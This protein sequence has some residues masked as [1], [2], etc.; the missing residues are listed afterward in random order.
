VRKRLGVERL[1]AR[2]LCSADLATAFTYELNRI[3]V[4]PETFPAAAPREWT[5]IAPSQPLAIHPQLQRTAFEHAAAMARDDFFA[6]RHPLGGPHP[7]GR[8]REAGYPLHAALPDDANHVELI[9]G[10]QAFS[11]PAATLTELLNDSSRPTRDRR[12]ALLGLDTVFAA[13]G[14]VGVGY[15][16][17]PDSHLE[18]Y[19]T[20]TL[21]HRTAADRFLTGVV[22]GDANANGRY[23]AGE[24]TSGVLVRSGALA[25]TS[26]ATG[27]YSLP[28]GPGVHELIVQANAEGP[29]QRQRVR[30]TDSNVQIDFPREAGPQ[31]NFRSRSLWTHPLRHLDVNASGTIEPLDALVVINHLNRHGP[32]PLSPAGTTSNLPLLDTN[33]DAAATPLDAL[34]V[35][36]YLNRDDSGGE[37]EPPARADAALAGAHTWLE[38]TRRGIT[39]NRQPTTDNRQPTTDN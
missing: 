2:R 7:N 1:Q 14:E 21:A 36:N 12:E 39:D 33:G 10:G 27:A 17:E 3:R 20:I 9:A 34:L 24:G 26:D 22:Y 18:H 4:A 35:I 11:T 29:Q 37:G 19:W 28:V 25:T 30:V 8:V 6:H 13:H 23:D 32:G 15:A 16:N 5:G 38:L 31:V